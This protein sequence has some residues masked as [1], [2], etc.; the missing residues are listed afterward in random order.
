MPPDHEQSAIDVPTTSGMSL[1]AVEIVPTQYYVGQMPLSVNATMP[2]FISES[3]STTLS[4]TYANL[5]ADPPSEVNGFAN[6]VNH[7][8]ATVE[9]TSASFTGSLSEI[10]QFTATVYDPYGVHSDVTSSSGLGE[11]GHF[12]AGHAAAAYPIHY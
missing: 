7:F 2:L 10:N 6:F 3:H 4:G 9:G 1:G 12:D 8:A 11:A 5:Y